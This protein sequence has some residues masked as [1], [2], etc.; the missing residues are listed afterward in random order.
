M[1]KQKKISYCSVFFILIS[2]FTITIP[3]RSN[4]G[5]TIINGT[6]IDSSTFSGN[7]FNPETNNTV[8]VSAPETNI[9]VDNSGEII[10]SPLA[11]ERLNKIAKRIFDNDLSSFDDNSNSVSS[12]LEMMLA[13]SRGNFATQE[14]NSSLQKSGVPKE[15]VKKFV[16]RLGGLFKASNSNLITNNSTKDSQELLENNLLINQ[17]SV[18]N[19]D[20]NQLNAAIKAYNNIVLK[21][22]LTTLKN[23][24]VNPDFLRI[25]KILKELR[26]S[27]NK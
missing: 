15:L 19:V 23:L 1:N 3:I 8:P 21:S 4:A 5:E 6:S 24:A 9:L 27:V 11:Q 13:R 16:T 22:N 20:I 14:F 18:I 12:I 26:V 2:C 17:K 7:T 25:N 10:I